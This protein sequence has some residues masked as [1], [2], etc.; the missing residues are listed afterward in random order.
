MILE[1]ERQ[2]VR[3]G[4]RRA[5]RFLWI[6][7]LATG[8][9]FPSA[10]AAGEDMTDAFARFDD[11]WQQYITIPEAERPSIVEKGVAGATTR[12][13]A[14]VKLIETDPAKAIR[15]AFAEEYHSALPKP[16]GAL[17]EIHARALARLDVST[18]DGTTHRR[19]TI[20]NQTWKASLYGPR[21][22]LSS[23]EEIPIHG[24]V[25]DGRMAVDATPLERFPDRESLLSVLRQSEGKKTCPICNEPGVIPGAVGDILMWFD[26]EEH[27]V[28]CEK[29]LIE[30]E[31]IP[32]AGE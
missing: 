8:S 5:L 13:A 14:M 27:L 31:T 1:Q 17:V 11:W 4:L 6:L 30:K 19:V 2:P 12:H 10:Q 21:L 3:K 18:K 22:E 23:R 29:A 28:T 7:L 16:I 15:L 20:G 9:G 26:S 25:L 24:V 32:E